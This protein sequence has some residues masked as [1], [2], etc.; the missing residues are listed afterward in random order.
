MGETVFHPVDR[1]KQFRVILEKTKTNL[2]VFQLKS[3]MAESLFFP[4]QDKKKWL[5][6][7][8]FQTL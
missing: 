3:S 6:P 8:A 7:E 2:K 1:K 4:M 5:Q